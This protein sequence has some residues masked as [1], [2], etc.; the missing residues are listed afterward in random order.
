MTRVLVT[1]ASGFVGRCL[2]ARL[3]ESGFDVIAAVRHPLA[4][5]HEEQVVV[6]ALA[7]TTSWGAALAG[8]D[9]VIHL[10]ARVHVM[11]ETSIDPYEAFRQVNV[12]STEA[13]ALSAAAHGIKRFIFL[14]SIKVNGEKTVDAPFGEQDA[15]NPQDPYAVSKWEAEQVLQ[16]ISSETGMEIV[17]LRPPLIYGPNVRANFLRLMRWVANGIPL[18]LASVHNLRSMLYLG[19]LVDAITT[20]IENPAVAGKT[21]LLSDGEDV[22]TSSLIRLMAESMSKPARLWPLSSRGLLLLGRLC[23]KS[24]EVERLVGSLQVDST[25]FGRDTGWTP[26]FALQQ[27]VAETV[28][29]YRGAYP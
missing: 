25:R 29:W 27:G 10:A 2:C 1:G 12:A 4:D 6:G 17:V 5:L 9:V 23:G 7:P 22:S 24:A 15:P 18:P 19:N 13:L 28:S 11:S 21:Y 8:V 26:P 20:C 16:R 3:T 14:S